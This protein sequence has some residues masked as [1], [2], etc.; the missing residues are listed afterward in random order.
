MQYSRWQHGVQETPT[1]CLLRGTFGSCLASSCLPSGISTLLRDC[2][3]EQ[4]PCSSPLTTVSPSLPSLSSPNLRLLHSA[5]QKGMICPTQ[6]LLPTQDISH[7][8]PAA[9]GFLDRHGRIY[10]PRAKAQSKVSR[11]PLVKGESISSPQHLPRRLA[12][13]TST[14]LHPCTIS[15]SSFSSVSQCSLENFCLV[16]PNCCR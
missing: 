14:F 10:S 8:L 12:P 15:T 5:A 11:R 6:T 9:S 2:Y 4:G 1:H 16:C 3:G 13:I 7:W